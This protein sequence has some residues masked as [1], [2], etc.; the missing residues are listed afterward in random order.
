MRQYF[1]NT[2]RFVVNLSKLQDIEMIETKCERCG[3][4]CR[5]GEGN[6]EARLLKRGAKNGYCVDCALT[7]FLKG[8][9]PLGMLIE[10][11]GIE[12]LRD[13]NFRTQIARLLI[14]GKSDAGIGEIDI[15]KVIGNWKLPISKKW[16]N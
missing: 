11:N 16:V 5:G 15:E 4:L 10:E 13:T 12:T 1:G 6:P 3:K 8:T 7:A 2:A 14:V 9:E